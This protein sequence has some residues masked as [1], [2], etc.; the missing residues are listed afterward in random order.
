M[1]FVWEAH[2]AHGRLGGAAA[3]SGPGDGVAHAAVGQPARVAAVVPQQLPGSEEL[4]HFGDLSTIMATSLHGF[5]VGQLGRVDQVVKSACGQKDR[6]SSGLWA[7]R[8]KPG[9]EAALQ[10]AGGTGKHP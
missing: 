9:A 6:G 10:Q 3:P 1:L 4:A 2:E 8:R 5:V 7:A